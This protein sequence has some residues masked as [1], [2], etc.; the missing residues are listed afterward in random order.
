MKV[1]V[2]GV[3]LFELTDIQKKVIA[4]DIQDE[5]FDADMKRRLQ[6]IL[7]HKYDQCF[8]RLK[9]EWDVKLQQNGVK[10]IPMD[11]DAYAAL[12]F[13]QPNY[14]NRSARDAASATRLVNPPAQ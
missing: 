6:W 4:N 9:Q 10:M 1:S 2:D 5:I 8:L 13:A 14:Q 11:P 3:D 7:T 12:V